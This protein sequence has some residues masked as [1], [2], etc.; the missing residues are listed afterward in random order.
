MPSRPASRGRASA[1]KQGRT[2]RGTK[3]AAALCLRVH[4]PMTCKKLSLRLLY[5]CICSALDERARTHCSR[6]SSSDPSRAARLRALTSSTVRLSA[7]RRYYAVRVSSCILA[8]WLAL[9][10]VAAGTRMGQY[11]RLIC[12]DSFLRDHELYP[13]FRC[14]RDVEF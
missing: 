10:S 14:E 8:P 7:E 12:V 3:D 6:V 2:D 4:G 11:G 1:A 13:L 9:L 5:Q